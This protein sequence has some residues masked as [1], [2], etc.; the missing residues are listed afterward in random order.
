MSDVNKEHLEYLKSLFAE[1]ISKR[2]V[3]EAQGNNAKVGISVCVN[4]TDVVL[5][6]PVYHGVCYLV[7]EYCNALVD[8]GILADDTDQYTM[9]E[10]YR[11]ITQTWDYKADRTYVVPYSMSNINASRAESTYDNY[12]VHGRNMFGTCEY[13]QNRWALV[14]YVHAELELALSLE[15]SDEA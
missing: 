10:Q 6:V 11:L 7:G 1:V 2:G 9:Y 13:S 4:G 12:A 15:S 3:L 5:R 8:V 14:E